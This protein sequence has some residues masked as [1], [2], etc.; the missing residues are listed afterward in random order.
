[1]D[2]FIA[3]LLTFWIPIRFIRRKC[4]GTVVDILRAK[5]LRAKSKSI[6]DILNSLAKPDNSVYLVQCSFYDPSGANFYSG[7]AERYACDLAKIIRNLGYQ[8]ILLQCGN[9]DSNKPWVKVHKDIIVIGINA[10]FKD[11]I[12]IISKMDAPKLTIYSGAINWERKYALHPSVLISHGVTWDYPANDT[13][14]NMLKGLLNVADMFVSVDTNT[15]SW[16]RATFPKTIEKNKLSMQYI[17]N[18][19]D[20]EQFEVTQDFYNKNSIK[21]LYPRRCCKERGF[22]LL[23]PVIPKILEKHENIK[24]ELVGYPHTNIIKEKIQNLTD[25]YPYNVK[26]YVADSENM[27]EVYKNADISIIPTLYSEGTSLSCIEAMAAGNAVIATN[28]GGLT[29]LIIDGFN[30]LLINPDEDSLYQAIEKLII[31]KE[32]RSKISYNAVNVAQEFSKSKWIEKWHTIITKFL[33]PQRQYHSL[34]ES[35]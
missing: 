9:K 17:P 34:I 33:E 8:P 24:F 19:V 16:F 29:D 15:I 31:N 18:Y 22:D 30:G 1:M 12:K 4:R 20:L 27:H 7:G 25:K 6:K 3:K 28:V 10:E 5:E 21:I 32:L 26:H 11:Y 13:D 2:K 14:I 35:K 23:L